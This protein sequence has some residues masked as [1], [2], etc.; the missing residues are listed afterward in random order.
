VRFA[1]TTLYEL[2]ARARLLAAKQRKD[3]ALLRAAEADAR[4]LLAHGETPER[5]FAQ[6]LLAN[7]A[8]QRGQRERGA[9]LLREGIG[10]LEPHG[11]ELWSL[12]ARCVLGRLIGGDTGDAVYR[13]AYN[14][15]ASRGVK[16]P[17]RIQGM[18][19]PGCEP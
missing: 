18:M 14:V 11:L 13:E 5:G 1:R 19:L 17:V 16:N 4:V 9:E 7:V 12:S 15:L 6:L 3:P 8:I 10:L 2:R